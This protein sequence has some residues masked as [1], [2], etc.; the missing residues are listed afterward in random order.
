MTK[1]R[2][3][4]SAAFQAANESYTVA[5]EARRRSDIDSASDVGIEIVILA[6]LILALAALAVTRASRGRERRLMEE[7]ML[8]LEQQRLALDDA[9]RLA[10][11]GSWSWDTEHDAPAAV[12]RH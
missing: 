5:M 2:S 11:V 1:P 9:Q 12:V 10:R 7:Q 6:V 3:D 8:V 4:A